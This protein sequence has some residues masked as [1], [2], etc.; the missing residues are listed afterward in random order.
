MS[1]AHMHKPFQGQPTDTHEISQAPIVYHLDAADQFCYVNRSWGWFAENNDG[2]HL[3]A[4]HILGKSL[5]DVMIE[6]D[7]CAWYGT[8]LAQVRAGA[9]VSL[10][11]RCDSPDRRRLLQLQMFTGTEGLVACVCSVETAVRRPFVRLLD[12]TAP[13]VSDTVRLCSWCGRLEGRSG[14]WVEV[15][16][17]VAQL[18]IAPSDPLPQIEYTTCPECAHYVAEQASGRLSGKSRSA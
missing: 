5:W 6:P 7:V 15:E 8:L 18:G 9:P 12:R 10:T 2:N 3:H 4:Q 14:M 13:R 16:T 1:T 11:L 17:A